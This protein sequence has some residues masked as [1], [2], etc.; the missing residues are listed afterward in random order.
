MT[1]ASVPWQVDKLEQSDAVRSEE[2]A[3][4]T[5]KPLVFSEYLLLFFL[6]LFLRTFWAVD[7]GNCLA[8]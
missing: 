3:K 1:F 7:E 8:D 5:D 4:S 2:E 6:T